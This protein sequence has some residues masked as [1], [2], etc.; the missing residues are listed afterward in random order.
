MG[1]LSSKAV[2]LPFI[3]RTSSQELSERANECGKTDKKAGVNF[4]PK[5]WI[6]IHS[7]FCFFA[8]C[9]NS[10][11]KI[12]SPGGI[13]Y[14]R[15][16]KINGSSLLLFLRKTRFSIQ[17]QVSKNWLISC[18]GTGWYRSERFLA[19]IV[20]SSVKFIECNFKSVFY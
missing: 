16:A 18:T 8:F 20:H 15:L 2:T 1:K 10:G 19:K 17:G 4:C 13:F 3:L 12:F 9:F 5:I 14:I 6:S 11:N 7:Y